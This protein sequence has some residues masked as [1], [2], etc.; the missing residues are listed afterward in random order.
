MPRFGTDDD[1][2]LKIAGT[3]R[4]PQI[5]TTFGNGSIVDM[6]DYSV[7][8]AAAD[9]WKDYSPVLHEQNLENLL[10]VKMFKQPYVSPLDNNISQPD[11]PAFRFPILHFCTM[12]GRLMPFWDFGNGKDRKCRKCNKDI[13]PSRFVAA[14]I[15]GHL[16]DFPY[17]WWVHNTKDNECPSNT[18]RVEFLDN[19]GG[20]ESIKIICTACGKHR[21]MAGSLGKDS[22]KGYK[23]HGKRPWIGRK[24]EHY[25]LTDCKA[26]M[27]ALQRGA[28]NLYFSVTESALTIP[29]WSNK[30]QSA[31]DGAFDNLYD[32][33]KSNPDE[34]SKRIIIRH[35]FRHLLSEGYTCEQ[36]LTEISKRFENTPAE[37]FQRKDIYSDEY[38]VFCGENQDDY[39]FK[40]TREKVP[41]SLKP[42]ITDIVLVN[43]L[44]EILALKGFRRISPDIPSPGDEKFKGYF[45]FE[46][47]CISLFKEDKNWLP[48]I[49]LLGEGIFIKLNENRI[50][51][52]EKYYRNRYDVLYKRLQK[53]NVTCDNI[54][55]CY[56]LL[57]TLSHLLI[58]QLS[59]E[60]GYS[61]ASIKERIYCTHPDSIKMNG[62]LLYTSSS[63][64][65]GSLGGLVRQGLPES[66]EIIFRHML[67]DSKWCSSDPVC[68]ESDSQGYDS[69]NM[70][71]C[72]AC[73]LLPET[74]CEKRNC[75]L[76]RASI[77]GK[78][79]SPDKDLAFFNGFV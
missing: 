76:D 79:N 6:P 33:W 10:K 57:H 42:Y 75:L 40:T 25:D 23:C 77:I 67:E 32:T 14:C 60:C 66:F 31:I 3:L 62:F 9:Y 39:Q 29:P 34:N 44:R 7:I 30:I 53:S 61:A 26:Q 36:I 58:R 73:T 51:G 18:L 46:K 8:M 27:L 17:S 45:D 13:V 41:A 54:S 2:K 50:T 65:D 35:E 71:A 59:I 5:I 63:D 20:L 74:S 4:R 43:R 52:W 69:L 78:F 49:E 48:A 37:S 72:H 64:S 16:E 38:L 15:N 47:D 12:C 70:A 56:I 11:I 1:D 24:K 19:S 55:P 28:S 21:D 22:L 68:I